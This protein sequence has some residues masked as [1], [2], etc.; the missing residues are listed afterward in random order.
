MRQILLIIFLSCTHWLISQPN[1]GLKV[2][3]AKAN[4]NRYALVIGN[5]NY[6]HIQ[7]L[8]NPENDAKA[9]ANTLRAL[10]FKVHILYNAD[11]NSILKAISSFGEIIQGENAIG[12]V[13]FSGH[14]IQVGNE[15][16]LIPIEANIR[17]EK[18][19]KDK[20]V[21]LQA[22]IR[23][24]NEANNRGN[25]V[26]LDACRNNPFMYQN[27]NR[28][29]VGGLAEGKAAG[30][31]FISY[32]TAP[33]QVAS[34][35]IGNHSP[36]TAALLDAMMLANI[37]IEQA[38]KQV[39]IKVETTTNG[40]Q[41]PWESTSLRSDFYFN[42]K[43]PSPPVTPP[44]SFTTKGNNTFAGDF[45]IFTD[46][47]DGQQYDW[48]RLRDGKMWMAE[49]LKYKTI[50]TWCYDNDPKNCEQ[51]GAIYS[52][53]AIQSACPVGWH[54]PTDN[55]W[56]ELAN[57]YGKAYNGY[58]GIK[59]QNIGEAA[60]KKAYELLMQK[61]VNGF[62]ST[63]SGHRTYYGTY[64]GLD[65]VGSYWTSTAGAKE[66]AIYYIFDD[67]TE[68]L[69]RDYEKKASALSCRCVKN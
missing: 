41:I 26:L 28:S 42:L 49:N 63:P 10:G 38:L 27:G 1:K 45:G 48:V 24:M 56:W 67:A 13:Y 8:L 30:G 11:Q 69:H 4:Q 5:S 32:A 35:G 57:H 62:E 53:Q 19:I 25:I 34:D 9:V 50:G 59:G 55:E 40:Q 23:K 3:K 65:H 14:G 15:N 31:I 68:R 66:V 20:A 29:V 37:T 2:I 46:H 51:N 60:G 18:E 43:P 64:F 33:G 44:D 54:L 36:Y 6:R 52:W 17:T 21:P 58:K 61:D 16:Y 47:R 7:S 39:R 22:I 12:L